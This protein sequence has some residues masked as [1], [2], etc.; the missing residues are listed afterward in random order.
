MPE[1]GDIN[2][3]PRANAAHAG[4]APDPVTVL[5]RYMQSG[6]RGITGN[7]FNFC[8][9]LCELTE[10]DIGRTELASGLLYGWYTLRGQK[11]DIIQL[12][13]TSAY[14]IICEINN[15]L[16][17]HLIDPHDYRDL[18]PQLH[19]FPLSILINK[20]EM[21]KDFKSALDL[22]RKKQIAEKQRN[23][24]RQ[25]RLQQE[26]TIDSILKR[27]TQARSG[28]VLHPIRGIKNIYAL[29]ERGFEPGICD[30]PDLWVDA[31]E[32]ATL[33]YKNKLNGEELLLIG[34]EKLQPVAELDR[35]EYK[36]GV[37]KS[38]DKPREFHEKHIRFN[39]ALPGEPPRNWKEEFFKGLEILTTYPE[40]LKNKTVADLEVMAR[41]IDN[42]IIERS[43]I[44]E[45][46]LPYDALFNKDTRTILMDTIAGNKPLPEIRKNLDY[47]EHT[48][49]IQ[50]A[51]RDCLFE[52]MGMGADGIVLYDHLKKMDREA[53]L[54][55]IQQ[56]SPHNKAGIK[57]ILEGIEIRGIAENQDF[58]E[59]IYTNGRLGATAIHKKRIKEIVLSILKNIPGKI[60]EE[61]ITIAMLPYIDE[62]GLDELDRIRQRILE[63]EE[64][65][66]ARRQQQND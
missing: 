53:T 41:A 13:E 5:L 52:L 4:T 57:K 27:I 12:Q 44:D 23:E 56:L 39:K 62:L 36:F 63:L 47:L 16:T 43:R 42:V 31:E 8:R 59:Y 24:D 18:K 25:N 55:C 48:G 49:V 14:E 21:D 35:I 20:F 37:A 38:K 26:D 15:E 6:F 11:K 45:G 58:K 60:N 64:V 40:E 51:Y 65:V 17:L 66:A 22:Y 10:G 30:N 7:A 3:A 54:A 46:L 2:A 19:I 61:N 32:F 28:D 50:Q 1:P 34:K 33:Y 29:I 9:A